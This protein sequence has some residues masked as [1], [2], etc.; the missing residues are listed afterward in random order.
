[1]AA[2]VIVILAVTVAVT[3]RAALHH[4]ATTMLTA[5]VSMT[6]ARVVMRALATASSAHFRLVTT[7]V[8]RHAKTA[9]SRRAKSVHSR[10]EV[11]ASRQNQRLQNRHSPSLLARC[12]YHAMPPRNR[13]SSP[14]SVI[15][16][17]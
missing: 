15:D 5:A 9:V 11:R 8:L 17:V 3:F 7:I 12:L 4:K 2:A 14:K 6:V 16:H 1:M 10:H 13:P